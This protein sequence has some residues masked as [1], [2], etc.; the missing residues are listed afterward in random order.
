MGGRLAVAVL[1]AAAVLAGCGGS[2]PHAT[3]S[4]TPRDGLLDAPPRIR[5]SGV[6][7]TVVVRATRVDDHGH[8]WTSTTAVPDLRH[9]P[10][11][12]LGG[13]DGG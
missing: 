8:R 13:S 1:G 6:G 7:D 2:S 11:R 10:T 5:V 4:A 12:L 9:D 3:I